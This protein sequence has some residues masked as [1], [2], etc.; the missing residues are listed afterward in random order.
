MLC[1]DVTVLD[2]GLVI[3]HGTPEEARRHDLVK[4]LYLGAAAAGAPA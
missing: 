1:E 4:Q 3:F 2:T